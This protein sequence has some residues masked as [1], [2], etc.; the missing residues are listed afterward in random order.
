[1][2]AYTIKCKGAAIWQNALMG[3][4]MEFP[5]G[6]KIYADYLFYRKKDA[7]RY[8]ESIKGNSS[9]EVVGLTM[10]EVKQ[11]NRKK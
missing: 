6:P 7:I 8:L 5:D 11:D 1:M 9:L 2:R 10:D 3:V 4:S